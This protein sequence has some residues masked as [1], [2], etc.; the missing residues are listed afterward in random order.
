MQY[1]VIDYSLVTK[2]D[3]K[4][5]DFSKKKCYVVNEAQ[6][7]ELLNKGKD[8]PPQIAVYKLGDCIIDWS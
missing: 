7:F 6:L 3:E 4:R 5:Q 2:E 1:L 8:N